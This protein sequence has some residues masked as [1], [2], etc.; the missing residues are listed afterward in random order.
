[1]MTRL[2]DEAQLVASLYTVNRLIGPLIAEME[3]AMLLMC[4]AFDP[5]NVARSAVHD[6]VNASARTH[7]A[8]ALILEHSQLGICMVCNKRAPRCTCSKKL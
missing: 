3:T 8:L 6:L 7:Q 5:K 2:R 1:M 4:D